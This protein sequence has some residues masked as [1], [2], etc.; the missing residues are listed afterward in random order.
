MSNKIPIIRTR[1]QQ[2]VYAQ[3]SQE[4]LFQ[5]WGKHYERNLMLVRCFIEKNISPEERAGLEK[6]RN[7]LGFLLGSDP[8]VIM[9]I[10]K[11]A[12]IAYPQ[13]LKDA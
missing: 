2:E 13:A 5:E 8:N 6:E 9:E 10:F 1:E 7:D 4:I 11:K 3:M 12:A